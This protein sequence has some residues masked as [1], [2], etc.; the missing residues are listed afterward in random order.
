MYNVVFESD[1]GEKYVFGK[2]G[3][4][5][6]DMDLGNG[7]SVNIG[8]SQG[9]SQIGETMQS[10]T[11]SG[12]TI[13]VNGAVYGN[14]QERKQAMRKVIAP[15]SC[16]R[17][18][19]DGEYY[20]RVCVKNAPTFSPVKNDGRF[21][22][23]L[24][25]P[26]PFFYRTSS[27]ISEIGSIKPMFT[28]PVNYAIPHKFGEKSDARYKNIFNDGDVKVPFS[29]YLRSN[30]ISKN[31]VIANLAT[32]KTLK[33]NGTLNPGDSVNIYRDDDNILKA[34]LISD[35][36]ASDI[37]S[38]IDESSDLFELEVG[39][40]LISANDDYGGSALTTKITFSPAVVALY[41][42]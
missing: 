20:T 1:S 23:Q 17:L 40:N 31:I 7:V 11:V 26:F 2:N 39:D 29:I 14:V 22:M 30:G 35:G 28:F 36:N 25:A 6:F 37:I 19:F 9:F 3:N 16:G 18:V 27:Q 34:E 10:R 12:R 32:F 33:I 21:T 5:V 8:T 42:S 4:T 41:E 15:F 24:F 13:S 38:W